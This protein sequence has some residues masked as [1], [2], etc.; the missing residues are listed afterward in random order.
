MA[1]YDSCTSIANGTL[2]L[3]AS[4]DVEKEAVAD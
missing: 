2:M 3:L 1:Y 4:D